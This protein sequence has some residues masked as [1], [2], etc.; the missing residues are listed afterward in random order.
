M[1]DMDTYPYSDHMASGVDTIALA[2]LTQYPDNGYFYWLWTFV[3]RTD[4][5]QAFTITTPVEYMTTIPTDPFG[6]VVAPGLGPYGYW[7]V[8]SAWEWGQDPKIAYIMFSFGPDLSY[9][10]NRA[11]DFRY[12]NPATCTDCGVLAKTG[13]PTQ[14]LLHGVST[15]DDYYVEGCFTYDATNGTMSKGDIWRVGP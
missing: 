10:L 15:H 11:G 3:I 1:V 9:Q 12:D 8:S 4:T 6:N 2:A 13:N 14:Q 5:Q 7:T